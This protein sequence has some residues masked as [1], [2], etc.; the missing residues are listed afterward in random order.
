MSLYLP[1]KV[2][3]TFSISLISSN[4]NI[5]IHLGSSLI[6]V[7]K[8]KKL[9]KVILEKCVNNTTVWKDQIK[10]INFICLDK[11]VICFD[12]LRLVRTN[13]DSLG[14]ITYF[15]T[16]LFIRMN[17]DLLLVRINPNT[18]YVRT[19]P[20]SSEQIVICPIK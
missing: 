10:K 16:K 5:K 3:V 6:S 20:N 11:Y 7:I 8:T 15:W 4:F 2:I 1:L 9:L 13:N 14:Q 19:N 12:E 18:V 17:N